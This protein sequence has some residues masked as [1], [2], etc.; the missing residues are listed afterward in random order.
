MHEVGIANSVLE[1]VHRELHKSPGSR[2][3]K[4]GLRIGEFAGVDNESL[5]FCF[6][7]LVKETE[8]EGLSLEIARGTE[9][10]LAI[11]FIEIEDAP[12]LEASQAVARETTT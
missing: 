6:E 5:K 7:A 8:Y 4:V 2:A 12:N 1:T 9:D 10:E 3:L 11:A